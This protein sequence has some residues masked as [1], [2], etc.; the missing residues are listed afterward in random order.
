MKKSQLRNII[1]ESIKQLMQE[2]NICTN[3]GSFVG[4]TWKDG[5]KTNMAS[6][7]GPPGSTLL[8][9]IPGRFVWSCNGGPCSPG[10]AGTSASVKIMQL[11][12][13]GLKAKN[14][15]VKRKAA[16]QA[17]QSNVNQS[18]QPEHYNQLEFKITHITM[19][20]SN[21]FGSTI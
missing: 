3:C 14:F 1:R 16:L 17:K 21:M 8:N 4:Q 15:L 6:K 10:Q 13:K 7:F 19:I 18:Q 11:S 5:F 20:A 9:Q 12:G 2:Q